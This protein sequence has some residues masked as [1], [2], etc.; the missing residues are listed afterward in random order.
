[1]ST[2]DDDHC[3]RLVTQMM[4]M[5]IYAQQQ[6]IGDYRQRLVKFALERLPQIL[7]QQ[8]NYYRDIVE[9]V[10]QTLNSVAGPHDALE[11]LIASMESY[12]ARFWNSW[13]TPW[14]K[15]VHTLAKLHIELIADGKAKDLE[16]RLLAIVLDE[17]RRDLRLRRHHS[18]VFY[19]DHYGPRFWKEK[20]QDFARV[21]EEV[22]QEQPQSGRH[23]GYIAEYLYSGL[24]L[25]ERAIEILL[26]AHQ[27]KILVRDQQVVLCDYLHQANRHAESI[28]ILEPL[29]EQLPDVMSYRTRLITAYGRSKRRQQM[30]SLLKAT[31]EHFRKE[32]RWE[33]SNVSLLANCCLDNR[34]YAESAGYYQEVIFIHR[35]TKPN[36]GSNTWTL[37]NY[38]SQQ[39][40]A[41]SGLGQAIKAVDAASAGVV[42]WG[43]K[44]SQRQSALFWLQQTI[45]KAENLDALVDQLDQRAERDGQDSPLIR[46]MV[47]KDYLRRDD[48]QKAVAQFQIS[49]EL[50]PNNLDTHQMLISAY[51]VLKDDQNV[52]LQILAQLD[53]DRHNL[54]L[55]QDLAKR[56]RDDPQLAERAVT[57]LVEAGPLEPANHQALAEVRQTQDRWNEAIDHWKHVVKL[58]SLE[59]DGWLNLAA[60]QVH[61]EDWRGAQQSI[62]QLDRTDWPERFENVK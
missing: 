23:V 16:P 51:E 1:M 41:Y 59:P 29:V 21:A 14:Q 56:L 20:S 18:R 50:Q 15:H 43:A 10:G 44:K 27:Q 17:L 32:G 48:P 58:R 36:N 12:P 6:K 62:Q 45:E 24:D 11:F 3:R 25:H 5:Y 46:Q 61:Q 28:P 60:A 26:I 53:V 9:K 33:E 8:D 39:S 42:L 54:A 47:G 4:R 2:S 31:D 37:S 30:L 35:R 52:I 57:T 7:R 19:H 55:Y 22:L 34:L 40:R 49:L 13:N 38:Y